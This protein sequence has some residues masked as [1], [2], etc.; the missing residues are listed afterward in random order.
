[1][2]EIIGPAGKDMQMLPPIVAA[3]QIL[4]DARNASQHWRSSGAAVHFAGASNRY[5]SAIR[6]VAA[7]SSPAGAQGIAGQ[8]S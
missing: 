5:S 3:F 2:S 1:V 7:I 6:Q 8:R 4:N